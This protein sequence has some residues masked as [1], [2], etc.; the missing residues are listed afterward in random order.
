MAK[1]TTWGFVA[2]GLAVALALAFFVSPYANSN[3]DGLEKVAA[4]KGIDTGVT[5]H[6]T[7][8][9][10]LADYGVRGVDDSRLSTGL[11]G[12]IG[13]IATFVVCFG[14]FVLVRAR[15]RAAPAMAGATTGAPGP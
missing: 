9:G 6:A 4:D 13:V 15:R 5:E 11:A 1:R 7:A 10:P 8:D 12:V 2:A 3:P 14:L